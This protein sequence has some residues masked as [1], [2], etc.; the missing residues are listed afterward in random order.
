MV[1]LTFLSGVNAGLTIGF[2]L[3]DVGGDPNLVTARLVSTDL[4]WEIDVSEASP[5]EADLWVVSDLASRTLRAVERGRRVVVG[6]KV[7]QVE[8]LGD[9]MEIGRVTEQIDTFLAQCCR[10]WWIAEENEQAL[11]IALGDLLEVA[12]A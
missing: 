2:T 1:R 11:V 5:E 7:F 12:Q 10:V 9:E 3:N 6:D 8:H 4:F